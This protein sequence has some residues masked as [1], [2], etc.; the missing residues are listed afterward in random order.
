MLEKFERQIDPDNVLPPAERAFRAEHA[1]KAHMK[2]MALKSAQA[3]RRRGAMQ[4][5]EPGTG[6]TRPGAA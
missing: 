4:R 3:R 2:R 5:R 6:P 1:R